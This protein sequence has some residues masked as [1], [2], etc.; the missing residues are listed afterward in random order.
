MQP[1]Q[2]PPLRSSPIQELEED[3]EDKEEEDAEDE[4]AAIADKLKTMEHVEALGLQYGIT[5]SRTQLVVVEAVSGR[6]LPTWMPVRN[7]WRLA[8]KTETQW[9][10]GG[11]QGEDYGA[12]GPAWPGDCDSRKSSS[13]V[14]GASSRRSSNGC[15]SDSSRK[16]SSGLFGSSSRKSS[17]DPFGDSSRKNSSGPFGDS[18]R[19]SSSGIIMPENVGQ[20][21]AKTAVLFLA[22]LQ[23]AQG[24][25]GPDERL[26]R[27]AGTSPRQVDDLMAELEV[28]RL[29][30]MYTALAVAV[31]EQRFPGQ[32]AAWQMIVN[33]ARRWLVAA[34]DDKAAKLL[35]SAGKLVARDL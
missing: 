13:G 25:F 9:S 18:S 1:L 28:R 19:K 32:A 15:A 2:N 10:N 6:E 8:S 4:A 26:D 21:P 3:A 16:N 7:A 34:T 33:K 35:D 20:L 22:S 23:T 17:S 11:R 12:E 14:S 5:S 27:L 24:A 30:V 29:D 31:L